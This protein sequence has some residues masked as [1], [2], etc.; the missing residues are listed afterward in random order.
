MAFIYTFD[1]QSFS[2]HILE[3]VC[4]GFFTKEHN[5]YFEKRVSSVFVKLNFHDLT[6][7]KKKIEEKMIYCLHIIVVLALGV[8]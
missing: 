2:F 6:S 8:S 4:K 1:W 3:S 5:T 7:T